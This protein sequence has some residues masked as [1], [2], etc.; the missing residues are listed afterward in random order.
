MIALLALFACQGDEQASCATGEAHHYVVSQLAFAPRQDG[1]AH[2]FDLDGTDEATCGHDDLVSPR[3]ESGIDNNFSSL[4]PFLFATEALALDSIIAQSIASGELMITLGLDG[5]DDWS[6]DDCVDFS[7]GRA[8]GVPLVAPDGVVLADQTLVPEA[9]I[10]PVQVDGYTEGNRLYAHDLAF[11]V[12][13]DVLNAVLDLQITNA[14]FWV[15]RRY[16]GALTG[17]F[18]GEL[19][20]YQ[21]T[22]ILERDDVQL[23]DLV[24]LVRNVADIPGEGG[25]C[26]AISVAFEFTALPVYLE[27]RPQQ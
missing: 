19:P 7:L 27:A 10:E 1:V 14:S 23:E 26:D 3:G 2:G 24:P 21:I 4:L 13:L 5:V 6:T 15:Q 8:G 25:D 20:I 18:A 11:N 22:E 9:T 12:P 16:D 17:V